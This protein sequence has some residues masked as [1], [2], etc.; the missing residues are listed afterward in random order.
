MK[1]IIEKALNYNGP[2]EHFKQSGLTIIYLSQELKEDK[3][4]VFPDNV[5]HAFFSPVTDELI[6]QTEKEHN[7]KFPTIYKELIRVSNGFSL[8]SGYLVFFG[9]PLGLWKGFSQKEKAFFYHDIIQVNKSDAPKKITNRYFVIGQ[10][11][12]N[13]IWFGIK[14]NKIFVIN[15]YGKQ[16]E[17]IDFINECI[18][19][20]EKYNSNFDETIAYIKDLYSNRS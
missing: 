2:I 5:A 8:E 19:S 11:Y 6:L 18:K 17:E 12:G 14:D 9:L 10:D 13:N 15:K 20:V 1:K 3:E 7:I 4:I 16:L